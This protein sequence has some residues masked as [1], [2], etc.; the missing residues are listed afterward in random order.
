MTA[1]LGVLMLETRFPR[2]LGDM[3]NPGTFAFPVRYRTLRQR[4][5]VVIFDRRGG[6]RCVAL[7]Q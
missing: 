1:T 4:A 2:P 7:D 5:A 3:G 6:A